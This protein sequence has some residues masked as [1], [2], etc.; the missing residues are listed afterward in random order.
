MDRNLSDL[1]PF[2]CVYLA[3]RRFV[4]VF[5]EEYAF[6]IFDD[7]IDCLERELK[8][9]LLAGDCS[10]TPLGRVFNKGQIE[11]ILMP[12]E[13]SIVPPSSELS[14]IPRVSSKLS[15]SDRLGI[16]EQLCV[17]VSQL[18]EN[19][20]I[21][22]DI[23]P[24]NLLLCS[25]GK[26]RLCDFAD[27]AVKG[28]NY[29]PRAGTLQYTT[30]SRCRTIP[31]RPLSIN[32]DLYAT[33]I[34]IWEIYTGCIP[35]DDIEE[36]LVEDLI[37]GGVRPNINLIDDAATAKRILAYLDAGE[38]SLP[39]SVFPQAR[40]CCIATDFSF[41]YCLATPL[42][43]YRKVVRCE[44]CVK[45]SAQNDCTYLHL[46]PLVTDTTNNLICIKCRPVEYY[47][48]NIK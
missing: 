36:D 1:Q 40:D 11:G 23:K 21:H 27:A 4:A 24:S 47:G 6:K 12:Y 10:V 22:G 43:T 33:G 35:F 14:H 7:G 3:A 28:E 34:S 25:D 46:M 31:V 44:S 38:P 2:R 45:N 8:M 30:P 37:R 32:D 9:M 39:N 48:V 13:T 26:L 16:I 29:I 41:Q 17:L 18:H 20:V 5:Q 42:H 15:R 19:G